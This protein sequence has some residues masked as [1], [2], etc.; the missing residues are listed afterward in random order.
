VKHLEPRLPS[1]VE[2]VHRRLGE[3]EASGLLRKPSVPSKS[4]R[5]SFCS[6]DYLGLASPS[7][8]STSQSSF[9]AGASRLVSGDHREH[10]DLERTAADWVGLASALAFTSG[11]AANVGALS[12]LVGPDD[13][14]V[15]DELNHASMIDGLRLSRGHV[16]VVP[17][18]DASA[19][20]MVL[21][22]SS[23]PRAWVV[24]ESYFSMDADGPALRDLRA[25]CDE[26]RAA[27]YIDEAHA[28]GVL[29]PE[30]RGRCFEAGIVADVLVGTFGKAVGAAGAFVA[31]SPEIRS[32]LW[33]RARSFVFS[34][35]LSPALA[36]AARS[37]IDRARIDGHLREA[38][39]ARA[40]E[41]R[42]GMLARGL[43][44]RGFGPIVPWV[45]GASDR[46]MRI[47]E[48]LNR[49]DV[50][51][52]AIRPPSVPEG[53]A[54]IRLTVTANHSSAD[55]AHALTAIDETLVCIAR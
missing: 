13:L 22:Q 9:G 17:H 45:I 41:F 55:I 37:G 46:A 53:T 29:G 25:I 6:N 21:A 42:S 24:T 26:F 32:W 5:P 19:V 10:L 4:K 40:L 28:L 1:A 15:S 34:T 33:N 27:L 54:R 14:V 23:R 38:V 2:Q 3:L 48:E 50:Y 12:A 36:E 7:W 44:V 16:E 49:R 18:L 20:R 8:Q 43:D 30:G 47:A 39:L 31:S 52:L 11:Y 51:A 35:A